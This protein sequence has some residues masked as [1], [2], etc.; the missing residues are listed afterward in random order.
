MNDVWDAWKA[1]FLE[2]VKCNTPTKSI[3]GMYNGLILN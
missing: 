1:L 2:A 3:K